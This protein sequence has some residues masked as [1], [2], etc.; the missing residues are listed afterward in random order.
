MHCEYR[1]KQQK[2]V[3]ELQNALNGG[4]RLSSTVECVADYAND[5]RF[6]LTS[7]ALVGH[8][9]SIK[10]E[11]I[12]QK[13]K[14]ISPQHHFYNSDAL[15]LTIQNVRVIADPAS[16]DDATIEHAKTAFGSVIADFEPLH[17]DLDGLLIMP[18][19]AAVVAYGEEKFFALCC[20]LRESLIKEGIPDNKEYIR[21]DVVFG[22]VTFCRYT[23]PPTSAF[24]AELERHRDVKFGAFVVDRIHLLA[25]NSVL[26][27][28]Y[29]KR[30]Q[31]FVLSANEK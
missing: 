1:L 18:T 13:L 26:S 15:H 20:R 17:F 10:L 9:L 16:F 29:T 30:L 21:D 23:E 28:A 8:V 22:N 2:A 12:I 7:V 31:E 14:K 27:P 6:C 19:S 25:T 5:Q 3:E 24:L 4:D 11:P